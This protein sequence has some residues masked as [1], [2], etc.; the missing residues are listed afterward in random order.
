MSAQVRL[1]NIL[2]F[3]LWAGADFTSAPHELEAENRRLWGLGKSVKK[4]SHFVSHSWADERFYPTQKVHLERASDAAQRENRAERARPLTPPPTSRR[5][6]THV[7]PHIAA[8]PFSPS[9]RP[10]PPR[11]VRCRT[12][13]GADDARIPLPAAAVGTAARLV[14]A[15]RHLLH[16]PRVR[17]RRHLPGGQRGVQVVAEQGPPIFL[18]WLPVVCP[19]PLPLSPLPLRRVEPLGRP[20]DVPPP[21]SPLTVCPPPPSPFF[22]GTLR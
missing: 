2:E 8:L 4:C 20:G 17:A 9:H 14:L 12:L 18:C 10:P 5:P 19:P 1:G 11:L 21:L 6:S 3:K 13:A 15:H 16:P 7:R 22:A